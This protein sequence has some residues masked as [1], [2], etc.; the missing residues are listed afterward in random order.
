MLIK[1]LY[2]GNKLQAAHVE[3]TFIIQILQNNLIH[4]YV[5][6]VISAHILV[7]TCT[8]IVKGYAFQHL[9][10]SQFWGIVM[11]LKFFKNVHA[12]SHV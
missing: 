3:I 5:I 6:R 2:N 8:V 4:V 11:S 12:F 1:C 7:H 10:I 9:E